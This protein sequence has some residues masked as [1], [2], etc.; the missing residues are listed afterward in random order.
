MTT[1]FLRERAARNTVREGFRIILQIR[2]TMLRRPPLSQNV[3]QN[4]IR[5]TVFPVKTLT[6]KIRLNKRRFFKFIVT[7][8]VYLRCGRGVFMKTARFHTVVKQET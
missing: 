8:L 5:K 2:I 3:P 6:A 7:I 4:T 1:V